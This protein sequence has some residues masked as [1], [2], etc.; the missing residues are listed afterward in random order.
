MSE[1]ASDP[2]AQDKA[3]ILEAALIEADFDGWSLETLRRAAD[4][5]GVSREIQRLAFPRGVMDLVG[6][7]SEAMDQAMAAALA[8][9]DLS[10]MKVREKIALGVRLRI[11]ALGAH[12]HAAYRAL[13]F[14]ALPV[15]AG[16]GVKLVYRTVD[17]IWRECG[18]QS[19]DFNFYTKRALLAGVYTTTLMHWLDDD[20]EGGAATW[21]LLAR[22]I[23]QVMR[24]EKVKAA[25]RRG[26]KG[27]PSPL[28][29]LGVL[30][31]PDR[32]RSH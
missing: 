26:L 9:R 4:K 8:E 6:Y 11:E 31:Y 25:V 16:E 18:D 7:Y 30:R 13:R 20:S 2:Y 17:R 21:E 3:E 5:A 14:L 23:D 19:T 10:A 29:V 27:L 24:I 15:F 1:P 22:R 32:T 28:K 12:K